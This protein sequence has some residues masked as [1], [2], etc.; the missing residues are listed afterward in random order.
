MTEQTTK[1]SLQA[2]SYLVEKMSIL[3][4]S[5]YF[6]DMGK[7]SV[8]S[9]LLGI[10]NIPILLREY[11]T[12][13]ATN[14]T[15]TTI[16]QNINSIINMLYVTNCLPNRNK[17][18][19][20]ITFLSQFQRMNTYI[21]EDYYK[22]NSVIFAIDKAC[23]ELCQITLEKSF[24]ACLASCI[25]IEFI[26]AMMNKKLNTYAKSHLIGDI[27]ILNESDLNANIFLD[28]LNNGAS[29]VEII[30]GVNDTIKIFSA[31]FS[32]LT[33]VFY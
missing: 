2:E 28:M 29:T 20:F 19:N 6:A 5:E 3:E 32:D 15:K 13:I 7:L 8:N 23:N 22:R 31:L 30:S 16:T 11:T 10:Y 18:E 24:F 17:V 9:F 4:N 25:T 26:I 27:F 33:K 21:S 14:L 12:L 1:L